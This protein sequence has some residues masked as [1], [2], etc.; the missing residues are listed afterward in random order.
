MVG[1]Y[2]SMCIGVYINVCCVWCVD[3][4]VRSVVYALSVWC[5]HECKE[6]GICMSVCDVYMSAC[7]LCGCT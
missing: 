4:C 6:C 2:V 7:I 3:E 1:V 5:V